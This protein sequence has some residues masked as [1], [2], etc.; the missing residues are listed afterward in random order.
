MKFDDSGSTF[1]D[2]LSIVDQDIDLIIDDLNKLAIKQEIPI[3]PVTIPGNKTI[4]PKEYFKGRPG[5]VRIKI[6]KPIN[7]KKISEKTIKNLNT[8][9]YSTIFEQLKN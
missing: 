1:Y 6:H 5:I 9:V 4:F 7:P 8:S 3:I 2:F